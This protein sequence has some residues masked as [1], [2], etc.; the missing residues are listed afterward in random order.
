M[1]D[2]IE[3]APQM[4]LQ[5]EHSVMSKSVKLEASLACA[6]LKNLEIGRAHV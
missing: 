6:S 3:Q 4:Q 2:E 1:I 5:K